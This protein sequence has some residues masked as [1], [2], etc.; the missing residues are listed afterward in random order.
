MSYPQPMKTSVLKEMAG[1]Q[2]YTRLLFPVFKHLLR[3]Y[4]VSGLCL[5]FRYAKILN[6]NGSETQRVTQS[7]LTE[8]VKFNN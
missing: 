8:P 3:T 7:L 6:G 1:R 2:A 4:S 5:Q